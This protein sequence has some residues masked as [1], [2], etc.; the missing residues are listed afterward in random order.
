MML[1]A[2]QVRDRLRSLIAER[3]ESQAQAARM[4]G[5]PKGNLNDILGG[6]RPLPDVLLTKLGLQR[7]EMY[8]WKR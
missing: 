1:T 6:R 7:V 5:I 4:W 8:E 2:D 3:Y